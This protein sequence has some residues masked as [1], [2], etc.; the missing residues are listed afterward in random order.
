MRIDLWINVAMIID[1]NIIMSHDSCKKK[2]RNSRK[3]LDF[4]NFDLYQL[5]LAIEKARQI[6]VRNTV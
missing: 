1:M 4:V 2:S 3:N 5:T 6:I